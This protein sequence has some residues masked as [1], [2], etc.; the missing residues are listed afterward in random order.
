MII[1][2]NKTPLLYAYQ[3]G[4]NA[5]TDVVL[6]RAIRHI[7]YGDEY[8]GPPPTTQLLLFTTGG[9]SP[10]A[11]VGESGR[12]FTSG[13]SSSAPTGWAK[14]K[15]AKS[16]KAS[17]GSFYCEVKI[18]EI[19]ATASIAVGVAIEGTAIT[20]AVGGVEN[21][22]DGGRYQYFTDGRKRS[23]GA[24]SS[25]ASTY[26]T[27]DIIGIL[28]KPVSGNTVIGFYKND[29]YLGDAFTIAGLTTN[30]EPHFCVYL[31]NTS[32]KS[33]I[34]SPAQIYLPEQTLAW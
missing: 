3:N 5:N 2:D 1:T 34:R 30:F 23:G 29:V 16:R 8:V 27:G 32:G 18:D 12:I 19:I 31:D 22:G 9:S 10:V 33:I 6:T 4:L 21:A 25:Y 24:Y 20:T 11:V 7:L 15:Y 17:D 26:G 13:P 14:A 28:L